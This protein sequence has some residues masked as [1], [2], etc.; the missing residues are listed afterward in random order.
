MD[1][2]APSQVDKITPLQVATVTVILA[3][4]SKFKSRR[5]RH[6]EQLRLGGP[7]RQGHVVDDDCAPMMYYW[8]LQTSAHSA[9]S[10]RWHNG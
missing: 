5:T 8:Q 1:I 4:V 3:Q 7:L 2:S 9:M 10:D 6:H